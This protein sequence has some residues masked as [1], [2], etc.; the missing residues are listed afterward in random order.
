MRFQALSFAASIVGAVALSSIGSASA[1]PVSHSPVA[2]GAAS[3]IELAQYRP[4]RGFHRRPP[5]CRT[6]VVR[7]RGPHGRWIVTKRRVCR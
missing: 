3:G 1:L 7:T 2:T 5:V 6:Q 4:G